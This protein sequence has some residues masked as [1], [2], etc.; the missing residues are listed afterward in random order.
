M[1]GRSV[2]KSLWEIDRFVEELAVVRRSLGLEQLHLFGNSWGGMLAIQYVLD[3]RPPLVSLVLASTPASCAR[4]NEDCAEVMAAFPES[5]RETIRHHEAHRYTG[6][7]EYSA[8]IL[9]QPPPRADTTSNRELYLHMAGPS[10]F[11]I[12]G[13]LRDWDVTE[14]LGEI[15]VPVLITCGE[16][17]E[18]RPAHPKDMRR[19]MPDA[20]LEV[21]AD[22]SHLAMAEVPEAYRARLN[23]FFDRV[24]RA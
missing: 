19:R 21:F 12:V 7:L 13:T 5:V 15:H 10:E 8:A 3:R 14:R 9:I 6:C 20:E 16:H 11:A 23:E 1:L 17:D 2:D 4:W 22:A 24:E 18:M